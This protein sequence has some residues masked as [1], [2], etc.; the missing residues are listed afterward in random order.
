MAVPLVVVHPV[1][2]LVLHVSNDSGKL[3]TELEDYKRVTRSDSRRKIFNWH[4]SFSRER[5]RAILQRKHFSL[6]KEEEVLLRLR[7]NVSRRFARPARRSY[8]ASVTVNST[9]TVK[10]ARSDARRPYTPAQ[11]L[12]KARGSRANRL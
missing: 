12:A 4:I 11:L 2:S 7:L 1:S 10:V 8:E 3:G 5:T 9:L 6:S